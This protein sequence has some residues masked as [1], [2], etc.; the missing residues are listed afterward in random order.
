MHQ[1][2]SELAPQSSS[3]NLSK[4]GREKWSTTKRKRPTGRQTQITIMATLFR[5]TKSY[6]LEGRFGFSLLTPCC[7]GNFS[8]FFWF[9]L[10]YPNYRYILNNRI[11][12]NRHSHFHLFPVL[13]PNMTQINLKVKC[14]ISRKTPGYA[15]KKLASRVGPQHKLSITHKEAVIWFT[16]VNK[17]ISKIL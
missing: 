15:A 1:L 5:I 12:K 7:P 16:E 6:L 13:H 14:R 11:T 10:F 8:N 2:P 9:V 3:P 4:Q 17:I